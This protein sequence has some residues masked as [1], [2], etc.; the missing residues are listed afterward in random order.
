VKEIVLPIVVPNNPTSVT[1]F[2]YA[3]PYPVR[4][5]EEFGAGHTWPGGIQYA[6]ISEIGYTCYQINADRELWNFFKQ[7]TLP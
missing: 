2:N 4:F 1:E 7:F 3:G 6:P 5:F